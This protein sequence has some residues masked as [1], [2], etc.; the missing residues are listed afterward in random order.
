MSRCTTCGAE[1]AAC[2]D[3]ARTGLPTVKY[4]GRNYRIRWT[5]LE[6]LDALARKGE[7]RTR[8]LRRVAD[9]WLGPLPLSGASLECAI[10]RALAHS[11]AAR[12]RLRPL[13]ESL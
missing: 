9:T 1:C 10:A 3:A 7:N 11:P 13:D 4:R 6:K 8:T 2:A 5:C 12:E